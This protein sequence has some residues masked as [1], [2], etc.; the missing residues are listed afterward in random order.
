MSESNKLEKHFQLNGIKPEKK[1][2]FKGFQIY[3]ADSGVHHDIK[4]RGFTLDEMEKFSLG[5]YM[6]IWAIGVGEK[7]FGYTPLFFEC[8]HDVNIDD[9]KSARLKSAEQQAKA[10]IN[11]GLKRD[12]F[13]AQA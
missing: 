7:L 13:Y 3:L 2:D 6:T 1:V 10:F 5:Y 11:E 4:D 8:L 9:R 12:L